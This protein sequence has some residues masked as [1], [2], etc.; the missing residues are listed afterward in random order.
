MQNNKSIKTSMKSW[1]YVNEQH[2]WINTKDVEFLD[3]EES[4]SGDIM[5]FEY[6]GAEYSSKIALGSRPG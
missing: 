3:I 6:D 1:V 4:F 5:T 2:G